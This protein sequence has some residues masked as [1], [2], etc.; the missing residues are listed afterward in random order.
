MDDARNYKKNDKDG[1]EENLTDAEARA[2][3]QKL[4]KKQVFYGKG[5]L[6]S[7]HMLKGEIEKP[8]KFIAGNFVAEYQGGMSCLLFFIMPQQYISRV[9]AVLICFTTSV[10]LSFFIEF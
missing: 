4:R 1:E 6:Q 10:S 8:W 5:R 2:K 9:F 3:Y 7:S